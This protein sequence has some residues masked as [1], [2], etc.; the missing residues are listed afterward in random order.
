MCGVLGGVYW[1]RDVPARGAIDAALALLAHRGP[2]ASGVLTGNGFFLAHRRLAILDLDRRSDQPM[3]RH[4]V[5]IS[6]NGEIYNYKKIRRRLEAKGFGFTTTSDTEVVLAAYLDRGLECLEEFEGMFA[7]AIVD[8][9]RRALVLARDKFGEKPLYYFSDDRGL[10]FAS[11]VRPLAHLLGQSNLQIDRQA[12]GLYFLFSYIPAPYAPYR[13]MC[14]LQPGHWARME[15]DQGRL[16]T[17]RYYDLKKRVRER[18]TSFAEAARAL[19]RQLTESVKQRLAASDVPV[20]VFLSGGIDSS[21]ITAIAATVAPDTVRAY[22]VSFPQD[23]DYDESTYAVEVAVRYPNIRHTVVPVVEGDLADFTQRTLSRLGEPYADASLVPAAYL[24]AQVEEKVA[25]GGDGAD[26]LLAGY[27]VYASLRA[28]S[29][30]PAWAKRLLMLLPAHRHPHAIGN[31][32]LRAAALFHGHLARSPAD[33]YLSWRH[34]ASTDLLLALGLDMTALADVKK[35][36]LDFRADNL[37][38]IQ[39]TD[40]E[41]NL[42]NDMLKKLDLASMFHSLE[43]RLPYLDSGFAEFALSLPASYHMQGLERKR[44]LRAALQDSLPAS[45]LTRPKKGFLLPIRKWFAEGRI[46]EELA[47]LIG[48]Q[49]LFDRAVLKKTAQR[50]SDGTEDNSVFLWEL[51]VYLKWLAGRGARDAG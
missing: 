31:S 26:E 25:L 42:P 14:Q 46:K 50:H 35:M 28:S 10:L 7:L 11:E 45:V 21:A 29:R 8:E 24:S 40:I 4:G 47:A 30:I 44:L 19:K 27:G 15:M 32:R 23:T 13:Q 34:Y 51:Y 48:E 6:F 36:L 43:V 17:S 18:Q 41:F 49:T 39:I 20:A 38:D 37:R 5:H 12:M 3:S 1:G 2:D 9:P 22:S 33:E 16:T